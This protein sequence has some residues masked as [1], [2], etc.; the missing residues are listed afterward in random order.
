MWTD[1]PMSFAIRYMRQAWVFS[2]M[3]T[4]IFP[5]AVVAVVDERRV[6]AEELRNCGTE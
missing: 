2:Y 1:L 3:G 6:E 5:G 4:K